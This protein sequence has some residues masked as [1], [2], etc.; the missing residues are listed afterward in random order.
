MQHTYCVETVDQSLQDICGNK[1]PFGGI[2]IV[3]GGDFRQILPIVPK[4]VQE[5]IVSASLKRSVLWP[6]VQVMTLT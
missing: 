4:G 6:K 5:Q 3:L 1:K 2:T